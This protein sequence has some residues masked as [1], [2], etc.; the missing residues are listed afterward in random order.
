MR[1]D[2][3]VQVASVSATSD[4]WGRQEEGLEKKISDCFECSRKRPAGALSVA[5]AAQEIYLLY[6]RMRMH[7][8]HDTAYTWIAM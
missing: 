1:F 2:D 8:K 5:G 7:E 4:E 3:I 6:V